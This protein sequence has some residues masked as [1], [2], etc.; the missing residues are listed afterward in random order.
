MAIMMV[1][2]LL[3]LLGMPPTVG[4]M[5]KAVIFSTAVDQGLVW[6]AIVAVLNTVIAAYYYLRIVAAIIFAEPETDEKITHGINELA[7]VAVA[8]TGAIALGIAPAYILDL[9]NRS[10]TIL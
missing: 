10:I 4:F 3:S 7:S 1:I 9:V 5:A 2:G 6:L 8:V